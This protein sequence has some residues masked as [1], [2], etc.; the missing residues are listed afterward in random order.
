MYCLPLLTF[1]FITFTC[2][3]V[4]AYDGVVHDDEVPAA[5]HRHNGVEAQAARTDRH[6]YI[7]FLADFFS[8]ELY[9]PCERKKSRKIWY[10]L[11]PL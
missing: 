2:K 9:I 8:L 3:F 11:L 5:G 6:L 10:P 4:Q 7:L 1:Y